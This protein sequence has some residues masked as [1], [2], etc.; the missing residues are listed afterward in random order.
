MAHVKR[1]W[2][3]IH[4]LED[5]MAVLAE[6]NTCRQVIEAHAFRNGSYDRIF[7]EAIDMEGGIE[8]LREFFS[9]EWEKMV[10]TIRE[11]DR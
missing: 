1:K 6:L 8:A 3:A 2:Q 11:G 5:A 9:Q 4:S 10:A 7:E